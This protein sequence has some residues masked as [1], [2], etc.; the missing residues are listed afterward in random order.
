[1]NAFPVCCALRPSVVVSLR[2][3]EVSKSGAKHLLMTTPMQESLPVKLCRLPQTRNSWRVRLRGPASTLPCAQ[4]IGP[5]AQPHLCAFLDERRS[6][7]PT[8]LPATP[9]DHAFRPRHPTGF[10]NK[11]NHDLKSLCERPCN[12]SPSGA[13]QESTSARL[14]WVTVCW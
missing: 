5:Q 10:C 3:R 14:C 6:M 2:I 1:M 7:L 9:S 13:A 12:A 8:F 4:P 11:H